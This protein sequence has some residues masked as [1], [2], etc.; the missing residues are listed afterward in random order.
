MYSFIVFVYMDEFNSREVR[1]REYMY[2]REQRGG[3]ERE[4][5]RER[6]R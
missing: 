4:R 2:V 5:D 1:L 3:R 6:E